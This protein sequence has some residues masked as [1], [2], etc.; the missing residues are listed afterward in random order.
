MPIITVD[1]TPLTREQKERLIME[2]TSIACSVT[3]LPESAMIVVINEAGPDN[4]GVGGMQ[5]SQMKH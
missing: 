2:F 3:G 4:F 1:T 5:L